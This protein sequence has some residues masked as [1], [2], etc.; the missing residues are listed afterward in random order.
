ME[1]KKITIEQ[2]TQVIRSVNYCG[3]D[4]EKWGVYTSD[5]V[6]DAQDVFDSHIPECLPAGGYFYAYLTNFQHNA[7]Y[8]SRKFAC[9]D[10]CTSDPLVDY[11]VLW[12]VG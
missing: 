7:F 10:A 8:E 6:F 5:V 4:I 9:Y 3:I 12:R 2:F 11:I 1:N